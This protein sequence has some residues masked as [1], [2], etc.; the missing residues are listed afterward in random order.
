MLARMEHNRWC[1]EQ[2]IYIKDLTKNG[3]EDLI[4]F[5]ELPEIEK[6]KDYNAVKKIPLLLAVQKIEIL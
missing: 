1:A 5:D 4:P 6:E 2:Y 3:L